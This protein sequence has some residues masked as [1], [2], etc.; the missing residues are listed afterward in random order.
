MSDF[1]RFLIIQL[2]AVLQYEYV[3]DIYGASYVIATLQSKSG[4]DVVILIR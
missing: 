4:S 2:I 1:F 3:I